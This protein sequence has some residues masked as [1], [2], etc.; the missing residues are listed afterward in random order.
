MDK[1]TSLQEFK[2]VCIH[3]SSSRSSLQD[4]PEELIQNILL[5]V[6]IKTLLQL[7]LLCK[8]WNSIISHPQFAKH[9]LLAS[10]THHQFLSSA[11]AAADTKIHIFSINSFFQKPPTPLG[12]CTITAHNLILGSCNGIVCLC[13][14]HQCHITLF[15]PS[16]GFASPPLPTH[17]SP[18]EVFSTFHGF[19]YDHVNDKY[20]VL[21]VTRVFSET[22]T[23]VYTFGENCRIRVVE[24]APLDPHP[25]GFLGKCVSG[26]LNWMAPKLGQNDS[27][28]QWVIL[29]FDLA[30]ET[31][32]EVML[33]DRNIDN[34]I[35][36]PMINVRKKG[37]W[38]VWVMKEYGVQDS[39]TM[40]MMVP[41][42]VTDHWPCTRNELCACRGCPPLDPLCVSEDGV[43][44]FKTTSSKLLLYHSKHGTFNC[45]RFRGDIW[46]YHESLVS[47]SS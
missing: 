9:H 17:L 20:K 30:S 34:N 31:F 23:K 47:P 40:L 28:D 6:S 8:S 46:S 38:G 42:F 29:S 5:R 7:K 33:P 18:G 10:T 3:K 12:F 41:R 27:I 35:C 22:V 44:L 2:R 25:S 32:S 19:G 13:H 43:A 16:T 15:N 39:W 26:T 37:C 36:K 14:V 11:T 24:N 45:F 4:L 21:L 1:E